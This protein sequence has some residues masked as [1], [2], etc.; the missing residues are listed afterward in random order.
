MSM[1]DRVRRIRQRSLDAKETLS[2][3]R[4]ELLTEFHE[5]HALHFSVSTPVQRAMAFEYLM[6]HKTISIGEGELIVGEKGPAPKAAP[7]YPELCCHSLDD[8]DILDSRP[9]TSFKVSP[10]TRQTYKD[11]IIP[12]W[13]GKSLREM[14]FNEM[15]QEWKA[16]YEAGIFTEFMEQRAPGHTVLDGKI[17]EK[18]MLE[19][20][21]EIDVGLAMLDYLNDPDAYAKQEELKAMRIAAKASIRLAE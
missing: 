8:L 3:E 18:G 17:Y 11:S 20:I 5:K 9:K 7:T 10:D 4:A 6:E 12:F 19:F 14:L 1:T 13:E 16:A 21:A 15:T 2:S